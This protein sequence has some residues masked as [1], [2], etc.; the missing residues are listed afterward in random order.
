MVCSCDTPWTFLLPLFLYVIVCLCM[1]VK[2]QFFIL[3][4]SLVIFGK[5]MSFWLS[6]CSVLI[7]VPLLQVRPSFPSV[8]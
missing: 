3:V 2:V 8:S 7:V 4:S 1:F 6:A 5:K